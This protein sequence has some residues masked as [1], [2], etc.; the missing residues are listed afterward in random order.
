MT[1]VTIWFVL[2]AYRVVLLLFCLF[3]VFYLGCAIPILMSKLLRFCDGT[4]FYKNR[5]I[6]PNKSLRLSKLSLHF[7]IIILL[8]VLEV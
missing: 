3:F 2:H 4:A 7:I 1:N 5:P 6:A 8:V